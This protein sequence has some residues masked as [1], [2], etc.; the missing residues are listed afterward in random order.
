[1][2]LATH[3]D[4]LCNALLRRPRFVPAVQWALQWLLVLA[5]R[6]LGPGRLSVYDRSVL[7]PARRPISLAD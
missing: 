7:G 2:L 1:M 5:T 3:L 6:L 4:R